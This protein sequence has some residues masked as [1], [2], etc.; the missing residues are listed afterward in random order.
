MAFENITLEKG[1][2]GVPGKNF[3]QVLEEL[4]GSQNYAGTPFAGLDAY[5]R[6]LKRFGIRVSGA[7]CDTVEKFFTSSQSA[8]LFPEYVARAVRQGMEMA[9]SL[10]DI[11]ATVTKIDTLDY[12]TVQTATA[13]DQKIEDPVAEGAAIPETVIKTA[14][15]LV[16]LHKRG[17]LIV[18][19]YEALRHHRLGHSAPDRCVHCA[20]TDEGRSGR[21]VKRRR[22]EYG[23]HRDGAYRCTDLQRPCDAVGQAFRL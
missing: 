8:A 22:H 15:S 21:A 9:S 2:Y 6:Q 1:M 3:T 17:R 18:S 12:R 14:G 5:Q 20:Q 19:S 23:H 13:S 11:A 7:N 4:D 16:T 10:P